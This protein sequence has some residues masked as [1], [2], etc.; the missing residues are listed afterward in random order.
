MLGKINEENPL[1][2]VDAFWDTID[3]IVGALDY[4]VS[5]NYLNSRAIRYEKPFLTALVHGL[6]CSSE[7]VIP[8]LTEDYNDKGVLNKQIYDNDLIW[9][10]PYMAEHAIQWAREVF[11][12]YFQD[13][14]ILNKLLTRSDLANKR[15]FYLN[16]MKDRVIIL[17]I[18]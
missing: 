16:K 17:I 7:I 18:F 2:G 1:L 3:I 9:N 4:R 12:L 6:N 13:F 14:S 5:K 10:F 15:R 8:H 11:I